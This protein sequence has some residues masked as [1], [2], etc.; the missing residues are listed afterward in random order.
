M[1]VP[2]THAG[3]WSGFFPGVLVLG[4]GMA[5]SVA[6]LTTTVMSSVDESQAGVASGINNAVARAAGLLAV[7][8]LGVVMLQV[9]SSE[10]RQRLSAIDLPETMRSTIYDQR[11]KLAGLNVDE[12]VNENSGG[13][14]NA[15]REVTQTI[16]ESFVRGFRVAMLIAAAMALVGSITSFFLIENKKR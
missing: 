5:I 8:V 13:T 2:G 10:L 4:L 16:K 1:A 6:P 3:Y 11:I 12:V 7:A 15:S 9:F 14:P